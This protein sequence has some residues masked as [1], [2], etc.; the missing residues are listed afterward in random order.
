MII[1]LEQHE[2]QRTTTTTPVELLSGYGQALAR[3]R[4]LKEGGKDWCRASFHAIAE[5]YGIR[6]GVNAES[7]GGDLRRV[8]KSIAELVRS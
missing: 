6:G 7:L 5:I 1:P 3:A 2:M 8:W 4:S